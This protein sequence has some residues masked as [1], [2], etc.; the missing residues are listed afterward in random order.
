[1]VRTV[2]FLEV[3]VNHPRKTSAVK[4]E[5]PRGRNSRAIRGGEEGRRMG[6]ET[7][8]AEVALKNRKGSTC[9]NAGTGFEGG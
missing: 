4:S 1:M 6:R 7:E 9:C 2:P 5:A 3:A 8:G